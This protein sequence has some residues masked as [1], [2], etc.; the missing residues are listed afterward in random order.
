[1]DSITQA[2]LGAAVGVAILGPTSKKKGA[3]LGAAIATLPDLDVCMG[4]FYNRLEMLS[5]H[6]GYS[7]AILVGLIAS[8]PITYLIKKS[9]W[10]RAISVTQLWIFTWLTLFTHVLLDAFTAYGTQLFL[11]FSD[12]RVSLDS[13]HIVDP[14]Y[15]VPIIIGLV[16]SLYLFKTDTTSR[17]ANNLGLVIS[18]IYLCSTLGTK[19]YVNNQFKAELRQQAIPFNQ[20]LTLPVGIA[21]SKWYGVATTEDGLY[22]HA[23]SLLEEEQPAFAYF[24]K[25]D[26]LLQQVDPTLVNKM[27]W[28]AKGYYC[29]Q[30]EGTTFRFYNLQ[31]DVRG[32]IENEQLRAPTKGYFLL[33]PVE[34]GGYSCE[35][36]THLL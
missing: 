7:H 6:R 17:R 8:F 9:N 29:V 28:F 27:K 15:T 3:I 12:Q 16:F 19:A 30:R 2:V 14:F 33:R 36:G 5:I 26:S 24:P 13:I 32:V 4:L 20:L 1:M 10:C 21:G 25:N 23:F 11:P 34:S 31:V 35:V 22:L 18:T